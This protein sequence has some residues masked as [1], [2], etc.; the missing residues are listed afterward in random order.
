MLHVSHVSQFSDFE[1]PNYFEQRGQ[2][3][4]AGEFP[5]HTSALV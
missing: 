4:L 2:E 5:N 1:D 3:D